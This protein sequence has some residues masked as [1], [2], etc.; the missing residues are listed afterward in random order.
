MVSVDSVPAVEVV[1]PKT[2]QFAEFVENI[3]LMIPAADVFDGPQIMVAIVVGSKPY[4]RMD[5]G[6]FVAGRVGL[7]VGVSAFGMLV[8]VVFLPRR[9]GGRV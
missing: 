5:V 1:V 9:I 7:S 6:V 2:K 4:I 3:D 8:G